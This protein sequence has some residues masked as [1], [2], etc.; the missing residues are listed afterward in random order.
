MPTLKQAKQA[1]LRRSRARFDSSWDPK[2]PTQAE[3]QSGNTEYPRAGHSYIYDRIYYETG[4][5]YILDEPEA[6]IASAVAEVAGSSEMSGEET[7]AEAIST[8]SSRPRARERTRD[9]HSQKCALVRKF[10][11]Q[12]TPYQVTP[13]PSLSS[14]S[15]WNTFWSDEMQ[16]W[17]SND[18][19]LIY[20]HGN[21]GQTGVDYTWRMKKK[22]YSI[23]A[24]SF[25]Q[26]LCKGPADVKVILECYLSTRFQ[27]RFALIKEARKTKRNIEI[28]GT[29]QTGQDDEGNLDPNVFTDE[30]LC[31]LQDVVEGCFSLRPRM[32][33]TCF[34]I[35]QLM[36]DI[37]DIPGNPYRIWLS[38]YEE[39][40][41]GEGDVQIWRM[42]INPKH[43]LETTKLVFHKDCTRDSAKERELEY[44]AGR[45]EHNGTKGPAVNFG[46][47][48]ED[49]GFIDEDAA[50]F[51]EVIAM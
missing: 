27:R 21:A 39:P 41:K 49:E 3:I 10:F 40:K 1:S 44:Y 2:F 9:V 30:L 24:F 25:I 50:D 33:R 8:P 15:A 7:S 22:P 47:D 46:P 37:P 18:L 14:E 36:A 28:V 4:K 26:K 20:H 38:E 45:R 29:G 13:V 42:R 48:G 51:D 35:P 5:V 31:K 11:T 23:N 32:S 6:A 43:V 16:E 12:H 17:H 19:I 34:S